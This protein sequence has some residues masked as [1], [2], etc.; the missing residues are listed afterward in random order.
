MSDNLPDVPEWSDSEKLKNEKEALDFYFSSHPLA[1]HEETL[2][3]FPDMKLAGKPEP[4]V[5]VFLNQ[6]KTLPV[7]W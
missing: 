1:Q 2:R 6:L 3:R 7:S 4:A 5:S